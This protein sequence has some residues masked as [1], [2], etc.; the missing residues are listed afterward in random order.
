M[1]N[2]RSSPLDIF[3]QTVK[4]TEQPS[5]QQLKHIAQ[6]ESKKSVTQLVQHK[7]EKIYEFSTKGTVPKQWEQFYNELEDQ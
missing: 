7:R 1:E 6:I 4:T 2:K 3:K 5:M